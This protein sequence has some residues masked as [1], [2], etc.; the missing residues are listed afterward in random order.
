MQKFFFIR[1]NGKYVKINFHEILFVEGCKN[2]IKIVTEFKSY[3]VLITMKRMEQLLPSNLFTRIHKSYIVSLD[4]IVEFDTE[5]VCLKEKQLPIG[6]QYRGSLEKTVVI[7]NYSLTET[8]IAE[9]YY[10]IPMLINGDTKR[11]FFEAG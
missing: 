8:M 4:K 5:K 2:Y 10:P 3:L 9:S 11:K 7:A 1:T 6:T